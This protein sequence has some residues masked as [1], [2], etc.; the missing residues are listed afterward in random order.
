MMEVTYLPNSALV[1]LQWGFGTLGLH[2][3]LEVLGNQI[4]LR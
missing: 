2:V 4:L 1:R 3:P